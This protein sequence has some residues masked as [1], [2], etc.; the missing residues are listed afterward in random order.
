MTSYYQLVFDESNDRI[1]GGYITLNK[2]NDRTTLAHLVKLT[3]INTRMGGQWNRRCQLQHQVLAP[4]LRL[5]QIWAWE[6]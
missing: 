4:V 6:W 1:I 3:F 5:A 2:L